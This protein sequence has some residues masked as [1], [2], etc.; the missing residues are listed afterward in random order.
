MFNANNFN[1]IK[2]HFNKK[3]QCKRS[4]D[5]FNYSDDYLF[6]LSLLSDQNNN[7][8]LI[9]KLNYLKNSD[10][11]FINKDK[12]F[13]DIFIIEKD[14][15]KRCIYCDKEF[16]KISDVKEHII[17]NCFY[18][19][20]KNNTNNFNN[21]YE[22]F[23]SNNDIKNSFN[24]NNITNITNITNNNN[25]NNNNINIYL[26]IKSPIPFDND[27]D[28]SK[29]DRIK[30]EHLVVSNFMYSKLLEEILKN[31]INL[32]VI[33]DKNTDT[34]IV[35]K[36]DIDNYI[37]MKSKDIIDNTMDKLKKHLLEINSTLK[38]NILI[39]CIDISKKIIENK[40]NTYKNN[41]VIQSSVKEIISKIYEDKKEDALNISKNFNNEIMKTINKGFY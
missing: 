23:D 5:S 12:L 10:I 20:I 34:N 8:E 26:E 36:N 40:Y 38:E 17:M 39:D 19:Q 14:K 31:E 13:N 30:K 1:D 2:R 24:T 25:N 22:I 3:K 6:I 7:N 27:W 41:K 35:Y 37:Q 16:N 18:N 32:N 15:N 4:I 28:T 33:I 11:I 21:K 9:D 29:I